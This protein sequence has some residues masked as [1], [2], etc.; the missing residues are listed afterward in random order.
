VHVAG[1][2]LR[3]RWC[4]AA[5]LVCL[6]W[7]LPHLAAAQLPPG[8]D[9]LINALLARLSQAQTLEDARVIESELSAQ[10]LKSG[11]PSIDLLMDRGLEAMREKDLDRAFYYFNEL[12]ILAPGFAGGWER[13]AAIYLAREDRPRAREDLEEALRLDP[14]HFYAMRRL[15]SLLLQL[16][17]KDEGL[18]LYR[19]SLALDPWLDDPA[20]GKTPVDDVAGN[21]LS[22]PVKKP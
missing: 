15:A 18:A 13:R 16:D 7:L 17:L 2:R 11:R 9:E 8:R 12:V 4:F 14:R 10:W 19:Q 20:R 1:Y 6:M 3:L 21:A 5:S 22:A